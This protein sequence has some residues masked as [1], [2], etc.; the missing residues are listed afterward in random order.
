MYRVAPLDI[1]AIFVRQDQEYLARKL[2][3]SFGK[4]IQSL[5]NFEN[6]TKA[7][8]IFTISFSRKSG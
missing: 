6:V 7:P 5:Q 8:K 4:Q 2:L 3:N 1:W